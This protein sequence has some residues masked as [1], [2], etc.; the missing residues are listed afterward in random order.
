MTTH[1]NGV[2]SMTSRMIEVLTLNSDPNLFCDPPYPTVVTFLNVHI[3][4]L[5]SSSFLYRDMSYNQAPRA[6]QHDPPLHC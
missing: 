6:G 1:P 5:A 4:L 3:C 2:S